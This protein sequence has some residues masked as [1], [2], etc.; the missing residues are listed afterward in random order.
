MSLLPYE[1]T[2]NDLAIE[3]AMQL[4]PLTIPSVMAEHVRHLAVEPYGIDMVERLTF[5]DEFLLALSTYEVRA[6]RHDV[7]SSI[8]VLPSVFFNGL[9]LF[10]MNEV[11][12]THDSIASGHT[13]E[14]L[15]EVRRIEEV[16]STVW[17]TE[18]C[19]NTISWLQVVIENDVVL[20]GL[21]THT[22][23]DGLIIP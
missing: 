8:G 23:I 17:L 18:W 11:L 21:S 16:V 12:R 13:P 20:I 4:D 1:P 6:N 22:H 14:P 10:P 5:F 3:A 15:F 19:R 2:I 7:A 9:P